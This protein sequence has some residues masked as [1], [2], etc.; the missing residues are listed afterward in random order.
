MSCSVRAAWLK[1]IRLSQGRLTD[2]G[3][4]IANL[5][6][7]SEGQTEK[8]LCTD[9]NLSLRLLRRY[10]LWLQDTKPW[11]STER[12][13][14]YSVCP[15]SG[16]ANASQ[17][18]CADIRLTSCQHI[19]RR[20]LCFCPVC[21][22]LLLKLKPVIWWNYWQSMCNCMWQHLYIFKIPTIMPFCTVLNMLWSLCSYKLQLANRSA[23]I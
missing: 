17:Q 13:V 1:I 9:L 2:S 3:H 23:K 5:S 20:G 18:L 7:S 8:T 12:C 4:L 15:C 21:A 22:Q 19:Q 11:K 6:P 16:G 10:H 14:V